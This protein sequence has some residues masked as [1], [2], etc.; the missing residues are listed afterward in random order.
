MEVQAL[1]I[2]QLLHKRYTVEQFFVFIFP[3]PIELYLGYR[4]CLKLVD[5]FE[6]IV[7]DGVLNFDS[8]GRVEVQK[9]RKEVDC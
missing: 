2:D 5:F 1:H 6:I 3:V 9:L 7:F 4:R 8:L